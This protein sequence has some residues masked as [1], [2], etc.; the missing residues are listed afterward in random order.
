MRLRSFFISIF[1]GMAVL[2]NSPDAQAP[3]KI[4][5]IVNSDTGNEPDD[6]QSWVRFLLYSN[7]YDIEGMIATTSKWLRDRVEPYTINAVVDAYEKARTNLMKH[8][9][10]YPTADAL[11]AV[12][13][14][15]LPLFA[16][17]GIGEGK[18]S[19]AS[20]LIIAA[21][22]KNDPRPIWVNFWGGTNCFIQACWKVKNTRS[23]ADYQKFLSKFRIYGIEYQDKANWG[24]PLTMDLAY[25]KELF[26]IFGWTWRGISSRGGDMSLCNNE[27]ID[28]NVRGHGPMG[29][30]NIYPY[31]AYIMEGDSPSWLY[32]F[33]SG[34]SAPNHPDWGGWGGRYTLNTELNKWTSS[35]TTQ[36]TS[37]I[38]RCMRASIA[39]GK[40]TSTIFRP[41]WTGA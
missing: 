31:I 8:E 40:P 14:A 22:D 19:E 26:Y 12:V 5:I 35:V 30:V 4:R 24:D 17:D 9:D 32:L 28:A 25:I 11:R 33:P 27:W 15:H 29:E 3:S 37:A 21:A 39:G 23:E 10:G 38:N 36:K 20:E 41:G 7:H 13:K 1:C 34:L 18:D 16:S 6:Q 2:L